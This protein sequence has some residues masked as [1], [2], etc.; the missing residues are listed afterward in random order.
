MK[1]KI[2]LL[3]IFSVLMCTILLLSVER[4]NTVEHQE[5]KHDDNQMNMDIQIAVLN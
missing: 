4:L 5:N 3:I 2:R 1:I